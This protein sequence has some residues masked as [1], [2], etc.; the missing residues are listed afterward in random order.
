MNFYDLKQKIRRFEAK[1]N[2]TTSKREKTY[3]KIASFLNNSVD[4]PST[5]RILYNIATEDGK[6]LNNP[7]AYIYGEWLGRVKNGMPLGRAV[8]GWVPPEDRVIIDAGENSGKLPLALQRAI[9]IQKSGKKIKRAIIGGVTM[10][11]ILILMT[12]FLMYIFAMNV[13]PA[14]AESIPIS[15]WRGIPVILAVGSVAVQNYMIPSIIAIIAVVIVCL[16]SLPRWTGPLRNKFDKFPP[17]SIYRLNAG[18]SFMLSISSLL[19]SGTKLPDCIRIMMRSSNPWFYERMSGTLWQIYNGKRLGA[20]L[21]NTGFCFPNEELVKDLRAFEE[22]DNFDEILESVGM[23]L[24]EDTVLNIQGQ[25]A[26]IRNIAIFVLGI[27]FAIIL[28]G[29]FSLQQMIAQSNS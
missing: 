3:M 10:P 26:V 11:I 13:I 16:W 27:T 6:K 17:W 12:C 9:L 5:L 24:L 22:L 14:F 2:F 29:V 23:D 19:S 21:Y 8:E 18:A 15:E 4:L 28:S 7:M 1:I 25:M 20:A